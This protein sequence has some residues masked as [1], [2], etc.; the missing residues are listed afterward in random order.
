MKEPGR[1][2]HSFDTMQ[3][4]KLLY[5]FPLFGWSKVIQVI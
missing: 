4:E 1:F 2:S 5:F 3:K